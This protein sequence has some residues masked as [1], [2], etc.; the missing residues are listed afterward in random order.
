M[1]GQ[2]MQRNAEG[3]RSKEEFL[4]Y[5]CVRTCNRV[6][7]GSVWKIWRD[8]AERGRTQEEVKHNIAGAEEEREEAKALNV[9]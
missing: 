4:Q 3:G 9:G 1:A 5:V 2:M 8:E 7:H 6:P